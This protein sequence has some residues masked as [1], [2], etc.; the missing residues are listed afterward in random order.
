MMLVEERLAE[1]R[2]DLLS[3]WVH[4][5][6]DGQKLDD[7]QLL[8]EHTMMI[9]GGSETTRNAISGGLEMLARHPDQRDWLAANPEGIPNAVDEI[10][11]WTTP[12]IR[13]SRTATRDA[14]VAGTPI[15]A[16]EELIMLYPAANRDPRKFPDPYRFDVRRKFRA[17]PISFG[18]GRHH[19]LGIHLARLEA[20][21]ALEQVLRRMPDFELDGDPVWNVSS[22]LRGPTHMPFKFTP[23]ARRS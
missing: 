17:K 10:I 2:D 15:K 3:I 23:G 7:D 12:F 21:V 8:F 1:P 11:R 20:K 18:F 22:F 16:G 19:C 6:F 5:E 4:S 14:E 13:M 9:V